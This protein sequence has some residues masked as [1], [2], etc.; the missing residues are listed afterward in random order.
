MK[1]FDPTDLL[2]PKET[3]GPITPQ[4]VEYLSGTKPWVRFMSVLMFVS[5]GFILLGAV[6]IL[7]VPS[8][9][10]GLSVLIAVIYFGLAALYVFPAYY[11]HQFAS[12]IRS[13]EQGGGNVAMED[14]LRSQRSFWRFV[15]I[16]AI[17][18][19][20]VYVLVIVFAVLA[21]MSAPR[22]PRAV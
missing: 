8:S 18:V 16:A 12:S 13:L 22:P 7:L 15:G 6:A 17:I 4:M 14:A 19:I 5:V 9:M 1:E 3:Y 10:G 21:G 20:V 11:L 2:P